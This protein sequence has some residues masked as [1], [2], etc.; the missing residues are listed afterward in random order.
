MVDHKPRSTAAVGEVSKTENSDSDIA[1][2]AVDESDASD[3]DGRHAWCYTNTHAYWRRVYNVVECAS[4]ENAAA[5]W[6]KHF[7]TSTYCVRLHN[8]QLVC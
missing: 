5:K 6:R 8:Q 1:T 3:Q 4:S 7:A 2:F